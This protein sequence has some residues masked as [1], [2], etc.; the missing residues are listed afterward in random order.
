[1]GATA[2]PLGGTEASEESASSGET[3][4]HAGSLEEHAN[5]SVFNPRLVLT[6]RTV[7][8]IKLMCGVF[9]KSECRL[10]NMQQHP[11]I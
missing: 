9:S 11:A 5:I 3:D 1:M 4:S 6:N 7:T 8:P 10:V 2:V